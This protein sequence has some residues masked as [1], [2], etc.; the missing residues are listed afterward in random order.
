[1]TISNQ[2]LGHQFTVSQVSGQIDIDTYINVLKR[3]EEIVYRSTVSPNSANIAFIGGVDISSSNNLSIADRSTS[4]IANR[5]RDISHINISGTDV[6]YVDTEDFIVTDTFTDETETVSAVPLFYKHTLSEDNVPRDSDGAL[7]TNVSLVSVQVLDTSL[8]AV[9]NEGIKIDY[10][11]GIVYNNLA[12]EFVDTSDYTIYYVK[13][14]VNNNGT[15]ITYVDLL[16]NT[17][18]FRIATFDDLEPDFSVKEGRKVYFVEE[19][20]SQFKITLPDDSA[21]AYQPIVESRIEI[22]PP[23][24]STDSE[25]WFVRVS[26]GTFFSGESET[27]YKYHLN[28]FLTQ[29]FIPEPPI[30]IIASEESTI[31]SKTIVKLDHENV[32]NGTDYDLYVSIQISKSDGTGVAAFTT[33]PDLE[34]DTADNGMTWTI[35]SNS[36]RYGIK[37]IDHKTGF[38]DID[39]LSMNTGWTAT[40]SYYYEEDKY[41]FNIIN[42]NPISNPDTIDHRVSLFIIPDSLGGSRTQNLYY[43]KIDRTGKV[44]ESNWDEFD[45]DTERLTDGK[46]LYYELY[47]SWRPAEDHNIFIEQYTVEGPPPAYYLVLG[48][49]TVSPA[50]KPVSL[51]RFD[52]RRR[53]GGIIDTMYDSVVEDYPEAKW[54]WDKGC[55][56]GNPFPGNASYM[57]EI[58]VD[59]LEGAGGVFTQQEVRDIVNKH[60]AAGVYPVAKA[61]GV[62]VTISGI[63][64]SDT[65]ITLE[66]DSDEY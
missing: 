62:D 11:E 5:D 60:T 36:T 57:V 42:F 8:Q 32:Y 16:S 2:S 23:V 59:V 9:S 26:N 20:G 21:Y 22:V 33:D 51:S 30:K 55:W 24:P 18:V 40:S 15:I 29:S 65:S 58:P 46:L 35:W 44:V 3:R 37:S 13:Y 4:L 34:G 53:G 52:S 27:T 45:N 61:Y 14:T 63:Y 50:T 41:E 49:I 47:P 54:V 66:W 6:F 31:L 17:N 25:A 12:A 43:L 64:P 38:V 28:E 1:M 7:D 39:G 56:D 48:D 19:E 10:D